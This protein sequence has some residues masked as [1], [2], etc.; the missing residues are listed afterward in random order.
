MRLRRPNDLATLHRDGVRVRVIGERENLDGDIRRLLDEAE[1][2]TKD[3]DNDGF[4]SLGYALVQ[5]GQRAFALS[6]QS[7]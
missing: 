6:S 1:E 2:L 3:N 4:A 5:S 7:P